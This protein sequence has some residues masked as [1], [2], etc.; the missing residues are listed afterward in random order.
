[1]CNTEAATSGA[2]TPYAETNALLEVMGGNE[3]AA[4]QIVAELLP[5]ERALLRHHLH[6][7]SGIVY[8][9]QKV[10]GEV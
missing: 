4:E 10:R 1:M 9:E 3:E 7:L 2:D 5:H 8:A 6:R